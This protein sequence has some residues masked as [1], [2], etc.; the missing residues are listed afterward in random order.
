MHESERD[1]RM[2]LAV[3]ARVTLISGPAECVYALT[4]TL[5]H[6]YGACIRVHLPAPAAHSCLPH[7]RLHSRSRRIRTHYGARA[8]VGDATTAL[9]VE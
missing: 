1:N 2:R 7:E 4:T 3:T 8:D 9:I 5:Y 6:G